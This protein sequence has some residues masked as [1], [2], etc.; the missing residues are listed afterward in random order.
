VIFNKE[1]CKMV[2]EAMVLTRGIRT[3]TLYKLEASTMS[4][5]YNSYVVGE[6]SS[7]TKRN[8]SSPIEKTMLWH[9]RM[10]HIGEKGLRVMKSK[11]MIEGISNYSLDFEFCK[12]CVFGK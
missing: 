6:D 2:R 1:S 9:Q 7:E 5:G 11:G 4:D 10:G 12:D 8:P 3:R